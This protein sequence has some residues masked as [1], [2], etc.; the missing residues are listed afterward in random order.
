M[1]EMMEKTNITMQFARQRM[2]IRRENKGRREKRSA[3][4]LINSKISCNY[5]MVTV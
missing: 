4:G 1:K 5:R 3:I 2:T